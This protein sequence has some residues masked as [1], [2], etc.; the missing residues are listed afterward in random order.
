MRTGWLA[1]LLVAALCAA[2]SAAWAFDPSHAL[3]DGVLKKHVVLLDE[4]T[5]R[6]LT[7]RSRNRYRDGR[8]EVSRIFDWYKE[9]FEPRADYFARH[10]VL[11]ADEAG[12][13][14]S[15]AQG[16]APLVF[17]EY[18]WSLN[19]AAAD[20][21]PDGRTGSGRNDVALAWLAGPTA[22]Y[23]HGV[24]GDA[25]EAG[26]LG[27]RL[28][29]GRELRFE[30]D[31][32]SVFEDLEPRVADLN[33][34]GRDEIVVVR[35][36]R[37]AGASLLILG[38]R[39]EAV[40]PLAESPPIGIPHR[41]LNPLGAA[42]VDGDG[43]L[44]LLVVLTPHIGGTLVGYE[45][46]GGRLKEK[47]RLPGFSNHVIG[48]RELALH[49]FHDVDGDGILDVVLPAADRRTLRILSFA[50]RE[51]KELRRIAL[52]APA[53]GNFELEGDRLIV[54]LADGR[55]YRVPL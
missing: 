49:A 8:L 43:R 33:G 22:R 37:D 2:G 48:S 7:D 46:G 17:L 18:D 28:R 3:W 54:P 1:R 16:R 44:D 41:W 14:A 35:S 23:A 36:R 13:R 10:A 27:V 32:D 6:F 42:D 24:L 12:H 38:V 47:W 45:Y 53:A 51:P 5:A 4:Q 34:D 30:L 29:E 9:D 52:P 55:R 39:N 19:D 26:A 11:L 21:L 31:E 50:G 25:I 40:Q 20:P 15:V